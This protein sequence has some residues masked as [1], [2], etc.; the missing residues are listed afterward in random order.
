MDSIEETILKAQTFDE[1]R[2][3]FDEYITKESSKTKILQVLKILR[4]KIEKPSDVV[5]I[6]NFYILLGELKELLLFL[7]SCDF[8]DNKIVKN[9][10]I[11]CEKD[12]NN[13]DIALDLCNSLDDNDVINLTQKASVL[14]KTGNSEKARETIEIA[15]GKGISHYN[16]KSYAAIIF[17]ITKDDDY[18]CRLCIPSIAGN[19]CRW[20]EVDFFSVIRL[21]KLLIKYENDIGNKRNVQVT[22]KILELCYNYIEKAV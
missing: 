8:Q 19:I 13:Y 2:Q 14:N 22:K 17:K 16:I 15:L 6:R 10:R 4:H 20:G 9:L 21:L 12:F 7:R 1:A 3:I 11:A 18:A 5:I